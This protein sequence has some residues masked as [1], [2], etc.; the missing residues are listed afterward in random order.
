MQGSAMDQARYYTALLLLMTAPGGMMYWFSIHPFIGFWRKIGPPGT[1]AIHLF[2]L[3]VLAGLVVLVRKPLLVVQFGSEPW[4]MVP[5]VLLFALSI[6]L[7]IQ[8][9]R[10]LTRKILMGIPE[11]A[12][13]RN[14]SPLLTKGPFA[15][16]RNPRYLQVILAIL[17]GALF[18]NYLASYAVFVAG[19]VI[20]R[21]VIWMEEKELR[22]R[23]GKSYDEYCARVPRLLPR[24]YSGESE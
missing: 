23:F 16:V 12:P 24:L 9:S 6:V 19:I 13:D 10:H 8:V 21:T 18:S 3:T 7:R 20:L 5:A 15:R 17:A 14:P 2:F 11:L 1:L 22:A 4:L